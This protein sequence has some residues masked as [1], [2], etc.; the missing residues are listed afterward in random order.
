MKKSIKKSITLF[1]AVC[2]VAVSGFAG[3]AMNVMAEPGDNP[4]TDD[5]KYTYDC[6]SDTVK[7]TSWRRKWNATKIYVYPVSGPTLYYRVQGTIKGV[8]YVTD[9][10]SD[11]VKISTGVRGS[12]ISYVWEDKN[13]YARLRLRRVHYA[14]EETI[15]YWSPDSTRAYT[16]FGSYRD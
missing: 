5:T 10:E 13:D 4:N 16:V 1:V 3:I 15:G 9:N 12:I 6:S 8:P 14:P 2:A 7:Y 11:T